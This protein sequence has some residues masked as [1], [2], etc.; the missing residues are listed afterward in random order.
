MVRPESE[1]HCRHSANGYSPPWLST[2]Q[3]IEW[4][5]LCNVPFCRGAGGCPPVASLLWTPFG[6]NPP[7]GGAGATWPPQRAGQGEPS[8][9]PRLN[10]EL[11]GDEGRG[12][13]EARTE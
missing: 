10:V 6:R 4:P 8:C 12:M 2:S 13:R 7:A 9:S 5:G 11:P 1:R 3:G